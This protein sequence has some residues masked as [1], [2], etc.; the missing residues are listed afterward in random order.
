MGG[1]D[2]LN[3]ESLN[4]DEY[5]LEIPLSTLLFLYLCRRDLQRR[6][7]EVFRG[8]LVRL[9]D[10]AFGVAREVRLDIDNRT[11]APFREYYEA[12]AYEVPMIASNARRN[13]DSYL[14]GKGIQVFYRTM[15][16]IDRVYPD[17][18]LR[19]RLRMIATVSVQTITEEGFHSFLAKARQALRKEFPVQ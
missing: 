2:S 15:R 19:A 13:L 18:S 5:D 6:F 14:I 16:S 11:L 1:M 8:N 10:W 17:V 7:P 9:I 4:L 12:R 3:L